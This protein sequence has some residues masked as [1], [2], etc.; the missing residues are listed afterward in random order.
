MVGTAFAAFAALAIAL[1][2]LPQAGFFFAGGCS[3]ET[4]TPTCPY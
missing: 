2:S 3:L 4:A 1:A